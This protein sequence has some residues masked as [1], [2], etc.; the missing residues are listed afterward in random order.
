VPAP[1]VKTDFGGSCLVVEVDPSIPG[2]AIVADLVVPKLKPPA[3][4]F[5]VPKLNPPLEEVV[6]ETFC[7]LKLKTV[8]VVGAGA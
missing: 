5:E 6:D 8:V 1:K 3:D 7:V 4:R 2:A